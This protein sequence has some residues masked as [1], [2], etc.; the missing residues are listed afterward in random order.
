[1]TGRTAK[2]LDLVIENDLGLSLEAIDELVDRLA[3]FSGA[4]VHHRPRHWV[5]LRFGAQTPSTFMTSSP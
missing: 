3:A 5:S 4:E 1:M 2:A